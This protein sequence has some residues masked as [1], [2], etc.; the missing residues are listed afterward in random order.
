MGGISAEDGEGMLRGWPNCQ[1]HGGTTCFTMPT[2]RVRTS[3]TVEVDR[4]WK[5]DSINA[6]GRARL[7]RRCGI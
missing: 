3:L 6:L 5:L 7:G 4:L 2:Y 1:E